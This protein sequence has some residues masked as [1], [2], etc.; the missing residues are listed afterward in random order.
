MARRRSGRRSKSGGGLMGKGMLGRKIG[1]GIIGSVIA[2]IAAVEI[3][4][5]V[6]PAQAQNPLVAGGV[7]LLA[8]GPVGAVTTFAYPKVMPNGI[9]GG[10]QASA[11]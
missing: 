2:G 5:M 7:G 1:M 3:L 10:Q 4:R 8:G 11:W 6:A 9:M